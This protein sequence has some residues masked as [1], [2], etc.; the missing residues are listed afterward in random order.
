MYV[1]EFSHRPA[2][3]KRIASGRR[4]EHAPIMPEESEELKKLKGDFALV[5]EVLRCVLRKSQG[6]HRTGEVARGN[7][8]LSAVLDEYEVPSMPPLR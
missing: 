8:I 3:A 1:H 2:P 7:R 6:I 4:N 5:L